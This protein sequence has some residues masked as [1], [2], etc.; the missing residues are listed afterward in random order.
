MDCGTSDFLFDDN[1]TFYARLNA[2]NIPATY[3][4]S[5]GNHDWQY[6]NRLLPDV[7][8]WMGFTPAD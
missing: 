4:I 1:Q 3:T 5:D 6:W 7:L 8:R 2:L